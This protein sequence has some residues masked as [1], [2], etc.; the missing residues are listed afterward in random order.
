MAHHKTA[1]HLVKTKASKVIKKRI[2]NS[3]ITVV[4]DLLQKKQGHKC[5]ICER[6]LRRLQ[7]TLDHCHDTGFIRAVLCRNCNGLEAKLCSLIAR[8]DI[9]KIGF[10]RIIINMARLRD[11]KILKKK[12]IHPNAETLLEQKNR[13]RARAR[14]L[15][16]QKKKATPKPKRKSKKGKK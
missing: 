6:D 11:P 12:W 14:Q 5:L 2:T 16:A 8:M 15:Y 1:K 7:P 3:Q 10:D 13:Q 4:R 9:S